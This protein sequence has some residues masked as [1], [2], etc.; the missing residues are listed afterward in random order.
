[1][2][3]S[4]S[5]AIERLRNW[6]RKG[7]KLYGL[8]LPKSSPLA[9]RFSGHVSLHEQVIIIAGEHDE[10]EVT[11]VF[12]PEMTYA[13]NNALL[14]IRSLGWRCVIF[15]DKPDYNLRLVPDQTAC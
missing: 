12:L 11:L 9:I 7:T 2:N 8:M 10:S 5:E 14:E 15:E 6:E 13:Y 1:M 4:V 3:L